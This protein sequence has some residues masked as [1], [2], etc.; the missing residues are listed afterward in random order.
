MVGEWALSSDQSKILKRR[1]VFLKSDDEY[2]WPKWPIY[3]RTMR[4]IIWLL[5][6]GKLPKLLDIYFNESGELGAWPFFSEE[7]YKVARTHPVYCAKNTQYNTKFIPR[8]HKKHVPTL[9]NF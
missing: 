9:Q 7:E 5:S 2:K 4:P 1:I 8:G 3:Y 6:F